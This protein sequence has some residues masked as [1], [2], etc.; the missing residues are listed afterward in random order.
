[1]C[2]CMWGDMQRC[3]QIF[4]YL[5]TAKP[6]FFSE[7]CT[8]LVPNPVLPLSRFCDLFSP[9]H[10]KQCPHWTVKLGARKTFSFEVLL[11]ASSRLN[12]PDSLSP[13]KSFVFSSL[14]QHCCSSL[15][16]LEQH[17]V[18]LIVRGPKLNCIS[19]SS[20]SGWTKSI[21]TQGNSS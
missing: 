19:E 18:L 10:S 20:S 12:T 13:L 7:D 1:M 2:C 3:G 5:L 14:H 6:E 15:H 17:N 21:A 4:A 11:S 8:D 9:I 16:T